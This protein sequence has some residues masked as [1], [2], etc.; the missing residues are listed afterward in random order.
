MSS[1]VDPRLTDYIARVPKVEL[2][3]HLEGGIRPETLFA[4]MRKNGLAGDARGPGDLAFL[5]RH[6]G[7]SDF[8]GHFKAAVTSLRSVDDIGR[9]ARDLFRDLSRQNILYAEVIFSAPIFT[10]LGLPLAEL[11]AAVAEAAGVVEEA[12]SRAVR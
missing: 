5:Y 4:I 9:V 2:H 6:T 3:V 8:L 11:L 7:L 12:A 1:R 10:R